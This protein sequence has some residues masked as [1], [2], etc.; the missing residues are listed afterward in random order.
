MKA[1]IPGAV[2]VGD[3]MVDACLR[4]ARAVEHDDVASISRNLRAGQY[5]AATLHRTELP[6]GREGPSATESRSRA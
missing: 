5:V 6:G 2:V 1:S 3:V 4:V